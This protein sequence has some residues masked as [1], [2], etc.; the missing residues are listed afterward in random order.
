[1]SSCSVAQ[2]ERP[3]DVLDGRRAE[4]TFIVG[5]HDQVILMPDSLAEPQ[6]IDT[7]LNTAGIRIETEESAHHRSHGSNLKIRAC[8]RGAVTPVEPAEVHGL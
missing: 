7:F 4:I 1:M 3:V 2:E 8:Q 6:Q 5:A